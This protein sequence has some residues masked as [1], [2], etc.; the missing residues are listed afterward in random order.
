MPYSVLSHEGL[1]SLS[2]ASALSK[3]LKQVI[4]FMVSLFLKKRLAKKMSSAR[5]PPAMIPPFLESSSWKQSVSVTQRSEPESQEPL[6]LSFPWVVWFFFHECVRAHTCASCI[7]R[8]E[9]VLNLASCKP[10]LTWV[11]RTNLRA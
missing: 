2:P 3:C 8:P 10:H 5:E 6:N 7:S 4:Y 9:E 1:M 11:Q